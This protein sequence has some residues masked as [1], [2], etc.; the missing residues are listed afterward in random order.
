MAEPDLLITAGFSDAKL[1]QEANKLISKYKQ[2]GDAA[3]KAFTDAS[4]AVV[5]SQKMRAHMREIDRLSKAYDPVYVAT[6]KYEGAV[7]QLD[8]ALAANVISQDRYNEELKQAQV[9]LGQASGAIQ[10]AAQRAG[11][12]GGQF[13]NV[14]YQ[15]QDF[16]VQVGAGTSATQAFAQQ[17]PQLASAFG[18]WGT[19]LGTAAAIL[20]PVSAALL[21]SGDSAEAMDDALK[22]LEKSTDAMTA[23]AEANAMPISELRIEYGALADEVARVNGAMAALTA[24]SARQN[25]LGTANSAGRRFGN[26][27]MPDL[28]VDWQGNVDINRQRAAQ[29]QQEQAMAALRRETGAT[30]E[31]AERLRMALYRMETSNSVEAVARDAENLLAIISEL[32]L[33]PGAD[34]AALASWGN[35]VS[36]THLTLPTILLV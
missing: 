22:E 8:K 36:Y 13:Q 23:A 12:A 1:A 15:I 24:L 35:P 31:Q 33:N 5:D 18:P 3:Q 11:S 26:L 21:A 25:L 29:R 14:G 4:G 16:A 9:E 20:V 34:T 32:A 30:E 7:K 6:K 19:A 27:Q 2:M 28:P 10:T 17:F